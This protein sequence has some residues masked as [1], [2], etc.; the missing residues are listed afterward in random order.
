MWSQI[1]DVLPELL[2]ASRTHG[3]I[4]I[5]LT[6]RHPRVGQYRFRSDLYLNCDRK[7][8]MSIFSCTGIPRN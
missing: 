3:R 8:L 2:L 7:I 6:D 4:L 5:L 1:F